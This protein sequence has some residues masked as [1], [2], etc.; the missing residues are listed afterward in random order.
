MERAPS[1]PASAH[2]CVKVSVG[3]PYS[4]WCSCGIGLFIETNAAQDGY[5]AF[6]AHVLQSNR[7]RDTAELIEPNRDALTSK[8][9]A[10]EALCDAADRELVLARATEVPPGFTYVPAIQ[11]NSQTVRAALAQGEEK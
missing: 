3:I 5:N 7:V 10:V 6:A 1:L 11:V 2:R 4:I 8:I 9:A